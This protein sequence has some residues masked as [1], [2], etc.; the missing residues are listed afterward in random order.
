MTMIPPAVIEIEAT[1]A[2]F[3]ATI[4][5]D[6]S[7]LADFAKQDTQTKLGGDDAL[8]T[9]KLAQARTQLANFARQVTNAP[10][11][12]NAVRFWTDVE[13]LK[14]TLASD[15]A[16]LDVNADIAPALAKIAE[17]RGALA[18]A[19]TDALSSK[20]SGFGRAAEIAALNKSLT[21]A[22]PAAPISMPMSA[23]PESV[24][25][26]RN[27]AAW[28]A[29]AASGGG[30]KKGL[31]LLALL[32]FGGRG[33][34][35]G[36][37]ALASFGS[38][39]AMM[40]FSPEHVIGTLGG[41]AGF[42]GAGML[43][44]GLLG[45]GGLGVLGTGMGTDLAGIGQAAGDIKNVVTAQNN[46]TQAVQ[47]YG[48]NSIQAL[49]AQRQLNATLHSF[50]PI[51]RS[52]V[53]AAANAEQH[54]KAL[55]DRFTGPA[56]KTGAQ[57]I[58]QGV[59]VGETFL[60]TIG[61][62]AATNMGIIKKDLQPLFSWLKS[63]SSTGGLGIF[64]NLERIFT[65][66]LP[67]AMQAV[68]RGI[69]LFAKTINVAAGYTGRFI[70]KLDAFL[71]RAN[72]AKGFAKWSKDIGHLIND[73]RIW[74]G[75]I[76]SVGRA[77]TGLMGPAQGTGKGIIQT[78][79]Q[80]IDKFDAWERT[81]KGAKSLTR[82]LKQHKAEIINLLKLLP[83]LISA[84]GRIELVAEPALTKVANAILK[85][86]NA[87]LRIPGVGKI[88]ALGVAFAVL[89]KQLKLVQI[90]KFV[91][92]LP[93]QAETFISNFSA[94]VTKLLPKLAA[95]VMGEDA[96]AGASTGMK[97]AMVGLSAVG[98]LVVAAGVYELIKHFGVLHGLMIAGAVA[99]AGLTVAFIALD[100]VPVVA[101]VVGIALAI[102]GLVAGI[103]ELVKHWSSVWKEI[104]SIVTS[105]VHGVERFLSNAWDHIKSVAIAAWNFIKAHLGII[106][107]IIARII[108]GP[109]GA[110]VA[111]L[112]THWNTVKSDAVKAWNAIIS[113]LRGIGS[114]IIGAFSAAGHWLL[115]AGTAVMTGLSSGISTGWH[116]IWNF[117]NSFGTKII[118]LFSGAGSWLVNAGKSIFE[119]LAKGIT[120]GVGA[121]L[122]KVKSVGGKIV[123][124][125]KSFFH[126]FS[127]SRVFADIGTNLM[128]G[129]AVGITGGARQP[130]GAMRTATRPLIAP[131]HATGSLGGSSASSMT[132]HI[133]ITV[134]GATGNPAQTGKAV[135]DALVQGLQQLV[136]SQRAGSQYA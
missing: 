97:L 82:L 85:V 19:G 114:D 69:E 54:F 79:T 29:A 45:L 50:S 56:E 90:V 88:V 10:I 49:D 44:G 31:G 80:M 103:I 94:S 128:Q 91:W 25:I 26:N 126:I 61:K 20:V 135:Q 119:G 38:L 83:P 65:G 120:G 15:P 108:M 51:A 86:V 17:L 5:K 2:K 70:T 3:L 75:F 37:G 66:H 76:K 99:V 12:A 53:L 24:A 55:F 77:L 35:F 136:T 33:G 112:F 100:A 118:N 63:S 46:L 1:D 87:I 6:K 23:Q 47:V 124:T 74:E 13:A 59:G 127:P 96:A 101:L 62:S 21:D 133:Q 81:T 73:F 60:P 95:L 89:A 36:L 129:L 115:S 110:L 32:G 30:G 84:F 121:V 107:P 52:A 122:D 92:D 14:A 7:L 57:I 102:A 8:L 113:F 93:S 116:D 39:G 78:L 109:V 28:A 34:R 111:F 41:L 18:L 4:A 42:A 58:T 134:N 43:G 130:L 16:T 48:K 22:F 123:S 132:N 72:S 11:G 131:L 27:L 67:T 64:K 9:A 104:R 117:V 105:V 106:L 71:G 68:T 40:G 125:V 98:I